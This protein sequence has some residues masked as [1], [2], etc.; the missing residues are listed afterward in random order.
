MNPTVRDVQD[1]LSVSPDAL[2]LSDSAFDA[3]VDRLIQ[4]ERERV[5]DAIEVDLGTTTTTETLSRPA[6]V[7]GPY[8][9][10]PERPVQSVESVALDTDRVGR[11]SVD[12]AEYA[13]EDSHLELLP[14]ADRGEWPTV[15]RSVTVTWTHGYPESDTPTPVVG[16]IIG[17]V[18]QTI[19]EIESDGISNESIDGQ[20]AD[21]R[22]PDE[23]VAQHIDRANQFDEPTF[24]GGSNIV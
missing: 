4:R 7:D 11:P 13:V 3:L 22:P 15:R 14:F 1:E 6:H 10:L 19:L 17:L 24:Y 2:G 12:T 5:A 21:Y 23:V 16:A 9:P 18:R 20:S 8:L